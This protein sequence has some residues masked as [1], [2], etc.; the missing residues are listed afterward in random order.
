MSA[1]IFISAYLFTNYWVSW[2]IF[3]HE[4]DIIDDIHSLFLYCTHWNLLPFPRFPLPLC[5]NRLSSLF[6][7]AFWFHRLRKTCNTSVYF[8]NLLW[9]TYCSPGYNP[10]LQMTHFH[11]SLLL[12]NPLLH[13][14]HIFFICDEH[15][16]CLYT[17]VMQNFISISLPIGINKYAEFNSFS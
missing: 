10:L 13:I 12:N 4:C 14:C 9:R 6:I 16:G 3:T 7:S 1:E 17:L 2:G 8:Y 11:F 15:Q 5:S